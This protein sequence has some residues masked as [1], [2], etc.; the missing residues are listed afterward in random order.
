MEQ[1]NSVGLVVISE[2]DMHRTLL[3]HR[4][5]LEDIYQRQGEDTI[6]TWSD[7]E[8]G[9]D[10]ALS[11]QE[12]VGCNHIWEH[13]Q[14]VQSQFQRTKAG[15][16]SSEAAVR[17]RYVDEFEQ[18]SVSLE[19]DFGDGPGAKPVELPEPEMGNLAELARMLGELS[20]YQ[21]DRVAGRMLRNG[22]VRRLLDLFRACED[23]EDSESLR[24]LHAILR[25]TIMLND[26]S[27]LEVLLSEENVMDVVGAL[28][29]DPELAGRQRHREFLRE[30]VVFKEVVPITDAG[31]RAKIHQTYR[32]SY[33]KDVV[34]PRVLDDATFATLSSLILFNNVEVLMALQADARFLPELF[35]AL[36]RAGPADAAFA[37]RLA[38]LRELTG[39]ARHLQA[40]ARAALLCKLAGLGLFE[41]A[42]AALA[43]GSEALRLR[44]LDVL[45]AAVAHDPG[46]LR[47]HLLRP[48]GRPLLGL[49]LQ[50]LLAGGAVG[51][52]EGAL[53][54]LRAL[55]DPEGAPATVQ[56]N[57]FLEL[58]YTT[59]MGQLVGVLAA[60]AEPE[61]AKAA[62]SALGLIVELLCFCVQHHSFRIKYY[63]LRNK[64]VESV[65]GLLGR[66]EKWLGVAAVRFLRACVGLKDEFY[67]RYLIRNNLF[68]PVIAAF[69]ANGARY[70]LLNSAVLE[71]V[72]FVRKENV[73]GLVSHLVEA[74]APRLAAVDYVDTFEQLRTRHE[75]NR[76]QFGMR[77]ASS[78]AATQQTV[79]EQRLR[80]DDRALDKDEE[81]YFSRED[82]DGDEPGDVAPLLGNGVALEAGDALRDAPPRLLPLVDYDDDDDADDGGGALRAGSAKRGLGSPGGLTAKRTRLGDER[83][84]GVPVGGSGAGLKAGLWRGRR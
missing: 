16:A 75:Q 20:L 6:I 17:R 14:Q 8:I 31:L 56:S 52:Q 32:L 78:G 61:G 69:L 18:A 54:L 2:E 48:E 68:E 28:E 23:L 4:I 25:G 51:L 84:R 11:F 47:E 22:Y 70:N 30:R 38:F 24:H 35:A 74:F 41:A 76:E 1:S 49:L 79:D 77:D 26:T 40:G 43:S 80:R 64:V 59:H 12:A 71:L 34:L 19:G 53:E 21:R 60:V 10:I 83:P 15:G 73:R 39:L 29:Y 27:L 66:R 37:D 55:L 57:G 45:L 50:P 58:F 62:P 65:L 3:I 13:V 81:D 7:P 72:E 67:N 9:T 42:G 63:V 44:A 46:P 33:L 5:S 36:R 82:E